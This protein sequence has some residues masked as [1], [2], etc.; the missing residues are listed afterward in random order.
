M[1]ISS[2]P[3]SVQLSLSDTERLLLPF[4]P[5]NELCEDIV[6]PYIPGSRVLSVDF[7]DFRDGE[8]GSA[9]KYAQ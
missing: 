9:K 5:V 1:R 7:T 6:L 4:V 8:E 3:P 2:N